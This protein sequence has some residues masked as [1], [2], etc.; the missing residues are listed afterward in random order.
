MGGLGVIVV[1]ASGCQ[2]EVCASTTGNISGMVLHWHLFPYLFIFADFSSFPF[3]EC[4]ISIHSFF[5]G[6]LASNSAATITFHMNTAS[7]LHGP[8]PLMR[9]HTHH[10]LSCWDWA[11]MGFFSLL[12]LLM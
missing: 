12:A 4:C 9:A 8:G 7:I 1:A 6:H 10:A 3:L 2:V 5:W 11:H